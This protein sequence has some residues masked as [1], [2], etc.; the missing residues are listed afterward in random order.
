[1]PG[2]AYHTHL[3]SQD[4]LNFLFSVYKKEN[5]LLTTSRAM[6]DKLTTQNRSSLRNLAQSWAYLTGSNHTHPKWLS[7]FLPFLLLNYSLFW[8][9]CTKSTA[10]NTSSENIADGKNIW[11]TENNSW[12]VFKTVKHLL[13]KQCLAANYFL[14]KKNFWCTTKKCENKN[15]T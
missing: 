8:P 1:M 10:A 6:T 4:T 12:G 7:E 2:H 14:K 5:E 3:E 15:L 9:V 13:V 11:L